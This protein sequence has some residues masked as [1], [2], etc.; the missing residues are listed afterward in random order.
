MVIARGWQQ[1]KTACRINC[2]FTLL[3]FRFGT[4]VWRKL[5]VKNPA[6]D[7]HLYRVYIRQSPHHI[8]LVIIGKLFPRGILIRETEFQVGIPKT[9]VWDRGVSFVQ[10][11]LQSKQT[12]FIIIIE[13][14]GADRRLGV[15]LRV[16]RTDRKR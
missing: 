16:R 13:S 6:D 4:V 12:P 2:E 8:T 9:G 15:T 7:L 1:K 3:A 14:P 10:R 5:L 11:T